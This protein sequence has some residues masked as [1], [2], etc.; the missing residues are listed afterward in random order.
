M[1]KLLSHIPS[2]SG[3]EARH[4]LRPA[5]EYLVA[6]SRNA[7]DAV[8]H[9]ITPD[10]ARLDARLLL[11]HALCRDEA[12][13][14]HEMLVSWDQNRVDKF[15]GLLLRR[16]KGEPVSRIRG[17]RE[18]WSL[19]F[20]ITAATLDPRPDSETLVEAALAWV[21]SDREKELRLLD[22]GTG[23]G[24]LL[25]ACLSE[26]TNARG[27]GIDISPG[28]VETATHNSEALGLAERA[29]FRCADFAS[30]QMDVGLF[31]IVLCNPPYIPSSDIED[32]APEVADFD[33][34][35]A[36]DGGADGLVIWRAVLPAI[37]AVLTDGGHAFLEIGAGQGDD[38]AAIAAGVGLKTL[39]RHRD[40]SG[41]IRCLELGHD[42]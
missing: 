18:F 22:L 3:V 41:E 29:D 6:T 25:L 42:G 35:S 26:L 11:A 10:D 15:A 31:D 36:L 12:V 23:S 37:Q 14:P 4:V 27:I 13:L 1:T 21:A 28:A 7:N 17:W 33:P 9:T 8:E 39:A 20:D 40:L 5:A 2:L 19:R 24:A 16:A 32:L 30:D 38:V 34:M